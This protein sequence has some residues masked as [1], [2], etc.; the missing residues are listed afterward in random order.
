MKKAD[1][2]VIHPSTMLVI[3]VSLMLFLNSSVNNQEKLIV[4]YPPTE[5]ND[6]FLYHPEAWNRIFNNVSAIVEFWNV[7]VPSRLEGECIPEVFQAYGA[8]IDLNNP[9]YAYCYVYVKIRNCYGLN[10]TLTQLGFIVR[11]VCFGHELNY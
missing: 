6:K 3:L 1:R 2:I 10:Q 11:N 4:I 8:R 5:A 9:E 7:S